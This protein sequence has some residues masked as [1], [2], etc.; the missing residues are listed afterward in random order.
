MQRNV[1]DQHRLTV[2]CDSLINTPF[3][4]NHIISPPDPQP[5]EPAPLP[6]PAPRLEREHAL[7]SIVEF[8]PLIPAPSVSIARASASNSDEPLAPF[9]S[10]ADLPVFPPDLS[11]YSSA[12]SSQDFRDEVDALL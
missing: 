5:V 8:P 9:M 11:G 12:P 1:S 4:V 7:H 2:S 6:A 3:T 10:V